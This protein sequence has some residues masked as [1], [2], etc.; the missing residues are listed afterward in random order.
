MSELLT[1]SGRFASR[2]LASG[3]LLLVSGIVLAQPA[4]NYCEPT[5]AVKDELRKIDKLSNGDLPYKLRHERA[6]LE[7]DYHPSDSVISGTR[8]RERI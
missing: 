2:L 5:P 3:L 1:L 6:R 7:I 4:V 8:V